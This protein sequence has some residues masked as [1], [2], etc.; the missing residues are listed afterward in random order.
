[1]RPLSTEDFACMDDDMGVNM[2]KRIREHGN[3][4]QR[5]MLKKAVHKVR[6]GG[7]VELI[8]LDERERERASWGRGGKKGR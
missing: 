3:R 6:K 7:D 1:M 8:D 4:E 5:R 2:Q